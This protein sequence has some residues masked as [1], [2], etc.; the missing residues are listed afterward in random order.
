MTCQRD[1]LR[2][3]VGSG[4]WSLIHTCSTT[5]LFSQV[6]PASNMTSRMWKIN[7][8]DI[9]FAKIT[10][11]VSIDF[12]RNL[13]EWLQR[14]TPLDKNL[15][16]RYWRNYSEYQPEP[17][18][19]FSKLTFSLGLVCWGIRLGT[20][21]VHILYQVRFMGMSEL[22]K[23]KCTFPNLNWISLGYIDL[24]ETKTRMF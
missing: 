13:L 21:L 3:I 6:V 19:I 24:K 10:I 9:F 11:W 16:T 7:K 4:Y 23:F 12:I 5:L 20:F 14:P 2:E 1:A 17:S 22:W 8:W 15:A 18:Q